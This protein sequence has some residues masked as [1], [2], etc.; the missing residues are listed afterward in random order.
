MNKKIIAL[1]LAI[2]FI[3]TAF[4][5]CKQKI[6]T[7]KIGGGEYP[8]YKDD[9]GEL[10]VN[11][12]NEMAI[13]VTDRQNKEV[14]TY[15]NG[16]PQTYWLPMNM[17][18]IGDGFIQGKNYKLNIPSGWEGNENGRVEKKRTDGKCY[19]KFAYLAK[20]KSGETLDTILKTQDE[21]NEILA[22][23]LK[24]EAKMNQLIQQNPDKAEEF[25]AIIGSECT[26]DKSTA[27]ISKDNIPCAVRVTKVVNPSGKILQYAE[28]YYFISDGKLYSVRYACDGGEGYDSSFNFG[29]Y[30]KDGFT[31]KAEKAEKP[32]T[33]T[34]TEATTK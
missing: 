6:E 20:V 10:V 21:T 11:E 5:A 17:E 32:E 13:L 23:A 12:K 33:T 16:E 29:Q 27:T 9:K 4:T 2:V 30:L 8:V 26:I 18:T 19:I 28:D 1:A 22:K 7:M 34:K 15:E 24:D 25:K 3:V 14:I 31:F